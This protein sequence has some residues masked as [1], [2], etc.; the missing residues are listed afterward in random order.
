MYLIDV[1]I[2]EALR[3]L[4]LALSM[5]P[6]WRSTALFASSEVNYLMNIT[7]LNSACPS[8]ALLNY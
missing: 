5:A 4:Y 7:V 3:R 2:S 8:V 6:L 1:A